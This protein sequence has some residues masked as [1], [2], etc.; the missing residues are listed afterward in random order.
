MKKFLHVNGD[1]MEQPL[2]GI[3]LVAFF[4]HAAFYVPLTNLRK[5]THEVN[6]LS[7]SII[8]VPPDLAGR[9]RF[10]DTL[11]EVIL[12]KSGTSPL[13]RILNYVLLNLKIS[14]FIC[15]FNLG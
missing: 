3:C 15:Y 9:I 7:R 1:S 11:D 6:P 13:S 14:W 10:D 2:P 5:I 12:Y 8:T 4:S